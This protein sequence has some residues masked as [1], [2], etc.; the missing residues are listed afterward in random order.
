[1]K[2]SLKRK[3]GNF[4]IDKRLIS[5]D[6]FI[7]N[8]FK[9]K[10]IS[11]LNLFSKTKK[12]ANKNIT[13]LDPKN[14]L[15]K[16]IEKK[17]LKLKKVS[18]K[19]TKSY[20]EVTI[21]IPFYSNLKGLYNLVINILENFDQKLTPFKILIA[22]D[23][24]EIDNLSDLF[25]FENIQ[26]LNQKENLGFLKNVNKAVESID[27]E[28]VFLL[29]DDI[30]I[31]SNILS[32]L[33][34]IFENHDNIGAI[35]P[36]IYSEYGELQEYGCGLDNNQNTV[37]YL[38]S[39][40]L[41]TS[42]FRRVSYV[43]GC[44]LF[45]KT[46]YWKYLN[47]FDEVFSPGYFEDFDFCMRLFYNLNKFT[48]A[49]ST[50]SIV[51]FEGV[52]HGKDPNNQNSIKHH[53]NYNKKL[54]YKKYFNEIKS[55]FHSDKYLINSYNFSL[56]W[57][58]SLLPAFDLDSGS[59]DT[60]NQIKFFLKNNCKVFFYAFDDPRSSEANPRYKY[61]SEINRHGAEVIINND[62][63][64]FESILLNLEVNFDYIVLTR[65]NVATSTLSKLKK[66]F[67]LS[68]FIFNTTDLHSLRLARTKYEYPSLE[69]LNEFGFEEEAKN[70]INTDFT[71]VVSLYEQKLIEKYF[72]IKPSLSMLKY[73]P[74]PDNFFNSTRDKNIIFIG[75]GQHTPNIESLNFLNSQM[76]IN[77]TNFQIDAFGS[78]QEKIVNQFFKNDLKI[79]FMG[80]LNSEYYYEVLSRYKIGIAFLLSGAGV[81]GKVLDYL[82]AGCYVICNDIA[83]EGIPLDLQKFI[84]I[85][86]KDN[87]LTDIDVHLALNPRSND[88]ISKIHK[89]LKYH[90]GENNF[91]KIYENM[92]NIKKYRYH[93]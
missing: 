25:D 19:I 73:F 81:K 6:G 90:Y 52:S 17:F 83:A 9:K 48:I 15:S 1:M 32:N 14:K 56:L 60:F 24:S 68:K 49:S 82:A 26:I 57:I 89:L 69:E 2:I 47:G 44:S 92:L 45:T 16:L 34:D 18:N 88:E 27:S 72:K 87:L 38:R 74:K 58:D 61:I 54:F 43:S 79:N 8:F 65:N 39:E 5:R 53:Q 75:S 28:Y 86:N 22:N 51:H 91:N 80:Y 30:V 33:L 29:N 50:S 41:F 62:Y 67:P 78:E 70:I 35:S 3:I 42:G 40:N 71:W 12:S 55:G 85:S 37:N 63:L 76:I 10:K 46:K 36:I 21:V 7:Y 66:I 20:D 84:F 77:K 13:L 23:K 11:S 93:N 31:E 64:N 59:Q 4:M